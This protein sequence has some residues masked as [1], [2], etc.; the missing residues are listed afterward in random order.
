[1][2]IIVIILLFFSTSIFAQGD[3]LAREYFKKG[4]FEKALY[5]YKKLYAKSP[6]NINYINQIVSTHQQLEQYDEAETFLLKLIEKINYPAF[7]VE[8]GYNY[9]LKN[10]LEN[11]TINY[12]KAIASIDVKA[13][14]AFSVARSFQNHTLLNEAVVSYEKAMVLNPDFNFNLQLAK[15]Y[16]EQGNIEKMF[17]SY[18]GFVESNPVSLSN[19]KR[20]INDFISEQSDNEYNIIFRKILLKKIQQEP[21]LLWNEMLSWL[22]IQQK[23]FKKAFIQEKA[24]F[25]R[26]PDNL[27][28]IESLALIASNEGENTVAKEIFVY[29]IEIAQDLDTILKAHYNLLQLE[30]KESSK[31]DYNIINTKY[32]KLFEKFGAF[33]QTLK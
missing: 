18:I 14:N 19:V 29:I 6:S 31:E 30:T 15:I 21:N 12:N 4:D 26:Q 9:Q 10:D 20:E 1:M 24:I 2:R 27:G 28:R 16:G 22:F 8:L 11:A 17:V 33:S 3:I 32:L 7:L 13:S 25:N 23:D 5:E